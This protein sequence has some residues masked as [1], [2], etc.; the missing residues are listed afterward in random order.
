LRETSSWSSSAHWNSAT[1]DPVRHGDHEQSRHACK[2]SND[3]GN[4]LS[5]NPASAALAER[6][7]MESRNPKIEMAIHTLQA[8]HNTVNRV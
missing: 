4:V 2:V 1:S 7:N 5:L 3:S 8:Q 6:M